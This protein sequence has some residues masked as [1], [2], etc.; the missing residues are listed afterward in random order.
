MGPG[1][2]V[3]DGRR[4]SLAV[5][6]RIDEVFQQ[7]DIAAGGDNVILFTMDQSWR[8]R[9]V[10]IRGGFLDGIG[11]AF[12]A[13][14]TCIIGPRGSGKSTLAEAV[15]YA[16]TG[17]D[18]ADKL[19]KDLFQSNLSRAVISVTTAPTSDGNAYVIRREARQPS[20]VSTLGGIA[21][22]NVDLDRGTFLPFDGYSSK[23]IEDIADE[24]LSGARRALVD[25][26]EPVRMAALRDAVQRALRALESNA[27]DIRSCRREN[28]SLVEEEQS[29]AHVRELLGGLPPPAQDDVAAKRV[30]EAARQTGHN[31]AEK[32][33]VAAAK[34]RI[35]ELSREI[36][37]FGQ[38]VAN[39]SVTI[40]V[41]GSTN[42]L[43]TTTVN[44]HL[45]SAASR[46]DERVT[47]IEQ[48][49]QRLAEDLAASTASL[50]AVHQQQAS[51]FAA[52]KDE[53]LHATQAARERAQA[54][55]D[56]HRLE[57]IEQELTSMR[58][59]EEVFLDDR[60][61]LRR[62]YNTARDSMSSLREEVAEQLESQAGQRVKISVRKNADKL[63]YRQ[64]VENALKGVGVRQHE[65]IVESI[66][67]GLRPEELAQIIQ[68][69]NSDEL[70]QIG[71]FGADR[72]RKILAGLEESIDPLD[73][74]IVQLDDEIAIELDVGTESKPILKDASNLSRGQ[75]CTA[76]L[77]LLLARRTAPIVIDQPE[78]NLDNH[79][80]FNTVVETIRR[81]KPQRQM[82]FIT[83]NA[84]IPV[85]A[86]AELIIVMDSDGKT[87]YMK[88]SG[89]L[90]ECK[91]E[92]I[93]LLEGGRAAFDMRRQ[94]Y[95]AK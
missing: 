79:F 11:V 76:L 47:D 83:H 63:P 27:D 95:D 55:A 38:K 19:R 69:R 93:D 59:R 61:R 78:D 40:S 43:M 49:L 70:E 30:Q 90:D 72:S 10:D 64:I 1:A 37:S 71:R 5:Q 22:Q 42:Y 29:L 33:N 51:D 2:A 67:N 3:G 25:D 58:K 14:L 13:G 77:P 91:A 68:S 50:D 54:E 31:S 60:R 87:G 66:T 24:A 74:E 53:D 56:V 16:F 4:T 57:Q 15:R 9:S 82:I 62:D 21:I 44:D 28:T 41:N 34:A 88:K 12:P 48:I 35:V 84:N 7:G 85:L 36:S 89:T 18:R 23:E 26:L 75:K 86:E 20:L 52:I 8:I 73:L 92:I 46:I 80:I 39:L 32:K 65:A 94:R 81:M 45:A 17:T 6:A